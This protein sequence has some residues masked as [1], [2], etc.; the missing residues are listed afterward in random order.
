M[1]S[2]F[3]MTPEIEAQL[4]FSARGSCGA[5]G[6]KDPDCCCSLCG[7][8]I[9]I[10]ENDPH[11]DEC[12]GCS[13]CGEIAILLFRT[14]AENYVTG[15]AQLHNMNSEIFP[16]LILLNYQQYKDNTAILELERNGPTITQG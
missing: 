15:Q 16:V 1:D 14:E 6:C 4:R 8:P 3:Q 2:S 10:P 13:A 5:P 12:E 9:G 11:Y 7:E